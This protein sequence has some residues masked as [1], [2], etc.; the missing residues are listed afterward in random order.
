MH[1]VLVLT[2]MVIAAACCATNFCAV[3]EKMQ[4]SSHLSKCALCGLSF[5]ATSTTC[6]SHVLSLSVSLLS[7]LPHTAAGDGHTADSKPSARLRAH[8]RTQETT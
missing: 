6:T 7:T 2:N 8:L 4:A 3:V 1:P 5:A